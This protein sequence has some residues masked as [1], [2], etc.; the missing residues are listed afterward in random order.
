[1]TGKTKNILL[2]HIGLALAQVIC[3]GA[4]AVELHRA[5][6]GNA[7]SWAYVFEWPLFALYAIYM[8]RRML[9]EERGRVTTTHP[10]NAAEDAARERYN[11]YLERVH[12]DEGGPSRGEG[13]PS[14]G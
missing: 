1:M 13:G 4:F 10:T 14:R 11:A 2:V 12:R 3:W 5:L 9:R 8:W 6:G 7:L